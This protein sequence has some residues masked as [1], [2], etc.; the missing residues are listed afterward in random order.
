MCHILSQLLERIKDCNVR[1]ANNNKNQEKSENL[2]GSSEDANSK[3]DGESVDLDTIHSFDPGIHVK[4]TAEERVGM[5]DN[6]LNKS[7]SVSH[8]FQKNIVSQDSR[9]G[10]VHTQLKI[11][12]TNETEAAKDRQTLCESN[13]KKVHNNNSNN[14]LSL[15]Q[16]EN[17]VGAISMVCD[18]TTSSNP[19][20]SKTEKDVIVGKR[21]I[22][23]CQDKS[24]QSKLLKCD[25]K[26]VL[27]TFSEE[28]LQSVVVQNKH[29]DQIL[30]CDTGTLTFKLLN[31]I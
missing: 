23:S 9:T 24:K 19:E 18:R 15:D 14:L 22:D 7:D 4:I 11:C 3:V 10:N 8:L 30:F 21:M 2:S 20:I 27:E 6:N 29:G 5:I 13:I 31:K 26:E 12:K 28:D 16:S 17:T 25:F 1:Q